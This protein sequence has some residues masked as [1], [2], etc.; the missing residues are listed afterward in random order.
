M[1]VAPRCGVSG[2]GT[3]LRGQVADTQPWA[4]RDSAAWEPESGAPGWNSD[5]VS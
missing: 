4:G 1:E 2:Q 3:G 5:P